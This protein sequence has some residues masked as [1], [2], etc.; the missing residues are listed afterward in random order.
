MQVIFLANQISW[1]GMHS[2]YER[3]PAYVRALG[4][5]TRS[6]VPQATF[7]HRA[8]GKAASL[9]RGHGRGIQ[10]DAF[11]R[12][13][14]ELALRADKRGL[15][16]LLYGDAHAPFWRDVP[17]PLLQRSV[18]PLHQPPSSMAESSIRA[19]PAYR[20]VILLWQ[21]ARDWFKSKL[22]GGTIRFIPHGVDVEFFTPGAPATGSDS[23]TSPRVLYSGLHLRNTAM[24]SRIVLAWHRHRGDLHFDLLVPPQGRTLPG[25]EK[26][27][28]LPN[29]TWHAGLPDTALRELYRQA[30]FLLLPMQD[31]GANTAVVEALACGLPIVTTDVGGIR[32]YGG[33]TL[34][35]VVKNDDD[36]G[37][38]AL[39]EDYLARPS[40]R[41]EVG[42]RCRAFAE[43]EL[44]W[45]TIA[46]RHLD[47]Y[48]EIAP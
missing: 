39:M 31:S 20:Y 48:R 30:R 28:G 5:G 13:Q 34:F 18:L 11:A 8:A 1:F 45:P 23:P 41:D 43:K 47:F 26:L 27:R 12:V 2:G 21:G 40:W 4:V 24:F 33:G 17:T 22:P 37:M 15:G 32:D 14:L 10:S 6:F 3:L 29:V 16:H 38:M 7:L 35:P 42:T 25:L 36:A 19:L 46:R 44:A 9:V